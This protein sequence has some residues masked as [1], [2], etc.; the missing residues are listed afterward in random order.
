MTKKPD[1]GSAAAAGRLDK[2]VDPNGAPLIFFDGAPS[3]GAGNGIVNI[4]LVATRNLADGAQVQRDLVAVAF[5]RC[6]IPA[7]KALR[8]AIDNALLLGAPGGGAEPN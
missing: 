6:S 8:V 4:T 2:V 5:L 1:Q 7:A 3:A